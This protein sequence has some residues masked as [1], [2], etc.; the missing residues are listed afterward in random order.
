M[1]IKEFAT[2]YGLEYSEVYNA[3]WLVKKRPLEWHNKQFDEDEL[4]KAVRI[5]QENKILK[6]KREYAKAKK[7]L[8]KVL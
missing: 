2:K 3:T 8:T 6:L 1:T 5:R 7:N 4:R